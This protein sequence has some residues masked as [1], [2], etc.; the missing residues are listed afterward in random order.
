MPLAQ[1]EQQ[2]S[3]P[4]RLRVL[5]FIRLWVETRFADFDYSMMTRLSHFIETVIAGGQLGRFAD[6]L[7]ALLRKKVRVSGRQV[8]I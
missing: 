3:Q 8:R 7:T 5:N 6:S 1:W 2:V 4:I